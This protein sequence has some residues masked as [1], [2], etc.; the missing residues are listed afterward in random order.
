M[1]LYNLAQMKGAE[2]DDAL[3]GVRMAQVN[4]SREDGSRKDWGLQ[5]T[6]GEEANLSRCGILEER[7][8]VERKLKSQHNGKN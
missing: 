7:S 3:N 6:M 4:S 1:D 2:S 8:N 5:K